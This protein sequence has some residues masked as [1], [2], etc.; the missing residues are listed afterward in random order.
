MKWHWAAWKMDCHIQPSLMPGRA[1]LKARV[2]DVCGRHCVPAPSTSTL[3]AASLDLGGMLFDGDE[4]HE[5]KWR[6]L[7]LMCR[8]DDMPSYMET[9]SGSLDR[10]DTH[11]GGPF[12]T[13]MVRV[14][15]R[16]QG[17]VYLPVPLA[18]KFLHTDGSVSVRKDGKWVPVECRQ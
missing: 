7:E 4:L 17:L 14:S 6:G 2:F 16:F 15:S 18:E 8:S 9:I 11:D 12:G 1:A 13:R 10:G 3:R 5:W